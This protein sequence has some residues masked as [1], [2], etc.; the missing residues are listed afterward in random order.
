VADNI[1]ITPGTGKTVA[2]DEVTI[3]GASA[4]VQRVK[5]TWGAAG[6]ASDASAS[7]PLPVT[8]A[9]VTGISDSRKVVTTAGSRVQLASL[10]CKEVILTAETDNTGIVVVGGSTV[11]AA[12]ATRT[13]V[14]LSAGDSF[15]F[16]IDNTSDIYLDSTVSGDG[17]TYVVLT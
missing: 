9:T 4:H 16:A 12:L 5:V 1:D 7:N 11:V 17:V 2:T 14:P 15:S 3:D 6:S 13:G 8:L 10:A